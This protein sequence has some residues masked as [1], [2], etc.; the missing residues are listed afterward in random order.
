MC[1]SASGSLFRHLHHRLGIRIASRL[2]ARRTWTVA[3]L[4]ALLADESGRLAQ[5]QAGDLAVR[6]VIE[7]SYA[8]LDAEQA[9]ASRLLSAST[10]A[11]LSL[12][13]S[14]GLL[15][16]NP[17]QVQALLERLIDAGLLMPVGPGHHQVHSL[18][19]LFA[20]SLRSP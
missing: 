7:Q 17:L 6:P 11:F 8:R 9:R 18:A 2:A 5:L 19:R 20:L 1:A 15:D 13:E 3:G 16:R 12:S 14:T 4:A 10:G